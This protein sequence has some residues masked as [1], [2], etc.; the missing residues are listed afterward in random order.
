M[1]LPTIIYGYLFIKEEFPKTQHIESDTVLNLKSLFTPL[2]IFIAI[3]MTLTATAGQH[4]QI[5]RRN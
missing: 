5:N 2:F 3:C 4:R 1:L